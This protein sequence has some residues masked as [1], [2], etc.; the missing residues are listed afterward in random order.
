MSTSSLKNTNSKKQLHNN[1]IST[2]ISKKIVHLQSIVKKTILAVQ[3]YK[4]LDIF[5]ANEYNIC[6]NN[7]ETIF[8]SLK[9]ILYPIQKQ[10][11]YDHEQ[12]INKLQ[13]INSE[14]STLFKTFGTENIEDLIGICFGQDFIKTNILNAQHTTK[15]EIM[16]QYVHPISYKAI[17][18]KSDYNKNKQ[19]NLAK[20]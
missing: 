6:T 15:F 18:W 3:K 2:I 14:L 13:D 8:S 19:E 20:K 16:K 17:P 4:S 12:I 5:G 9:Q 10:Q 1:A 7:L 11:N